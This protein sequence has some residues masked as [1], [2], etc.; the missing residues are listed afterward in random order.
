MYF[1]LPSMFKEPAAKIS[2]FTAEPISASSPTVVKSAVNCTLLSMIKL[3]LVNLTGVVVEVNVQP[4][5]DRVEDGAIKSICLRVNSV[6]VGVN[7]LSVG[8]G[9]Y[10]KFMPLLIFN[11]P[12]GIMVIVPV[13]IKS[14]LVVPSIAFV[15]A[16][17]I[18]Q[19]PSIVK[20]ALF[21][22][23]LSKQEKPA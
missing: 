23:P 14:K 4:F 6:G 2:T 7:K 10:L 12:A 3:P 13:V 17:S 15:T 18:L 16:D 20:P 9:M 21:V 5:K 11:L 8:L 1:T 19:M 22:P